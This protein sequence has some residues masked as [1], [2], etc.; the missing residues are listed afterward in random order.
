MYMDFQAIGIDEGQFFPDVSPLFSSV[1]KRQGATEVKR[2][3][4]R[5]RGRLKAWLDFDQKL[6]LMVGGGGG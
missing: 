1:F 5:G 6:I 3:E 4:E 2:E